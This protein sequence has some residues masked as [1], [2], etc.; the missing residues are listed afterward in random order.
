MGMDSGCC[1][2]CWYAVC[3]WWIVDDDNGRVRVC[4]YGGHLG[5]LWGVLWCMACAGIGGAYG[6]QSLPGML[7]HSRAIRLIARIYYCKYLHLSSIDAH[8][9]IVIASV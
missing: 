7:V 9:Y 4:A 6:M 5:A 8:L 1:M 2:V 3:T